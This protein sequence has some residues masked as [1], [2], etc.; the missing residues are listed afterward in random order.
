M[1]RPDLFLNRKFLRLVHVLRE[2]LSHVVG[3]LEC[4]WHVCYQSGD[5]VL[6]DATGV[7]L[8]AKYPGEPGRLAAALL[9][10]GFLDAVGDG[11]YAV[12]DL[13]DHAPTYVQKRIQRE[14]ERRE[15]GEQRKIAFAPRNRPRTAEWRAKTDLGGLREPNSDLGSLNQTKA[16]LGFPPTPTPTPNTASLRDACS[17]PP[18]T[19][20]SE[21]PADPVVMTFDTVGKGPKTWDLTASKLQEY[22]DSYPALDVLA[23]CREARQWCIDNPTKRKT[24]R[25]MTKFL[26]GW[27]AREQ[28]RGG[29]SRPQPQ[30]ARASREEWLARKARENES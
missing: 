6:G 26:G 7:E 19:E 27:L 4:M 28:N 20:A 21:P 17:E 23:V 24:A 14:V 3:Y 1:A 18:G 16:D 8:A 12:H 2:P 22:R 15:R 25:G 30:P 9:E 11:T 10:C 5:A 29:R 13:Y